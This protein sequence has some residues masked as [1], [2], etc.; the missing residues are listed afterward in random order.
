[1]TVVAEPA[2]AGGPATRRAAAGGVVPVAAGLAVFGLATYG[3]LAFAGRAL[4]EVAFAPLSVMWTLLN[5]VGIGL[6]LPFEQ[7]LGRT[8]AAR[9]AAGEGN[10]PVV[11]HAARAAGLVLA[12]SALVAAAGAAWLAP[13]LF[14]GSF[15]LV[16]LTVV[17]LAAMAL[18]YL[19]RGLLSGTGRFGGYGAQLAVDGVL[20]VGG[21]GALALAGVRSVAAFAVVLAVA[22]LLAVLVTTGRPS[23]LIT[24]GPDHGGRGAAV[25]LGTLVAASVASQLLANAGPVVVELL[26]GPDEAAAAGLFTA[27]LVI[28]RVPL[29][30]FAAVQ[31]V[32]LP[33]LAAL[34]AAGER[35]ALRRRAGVVAA[36]TGVLGGI[37]TVVVWLVGPWLVRL[38]FGPG[39]TIG[40][41][42]LAAIAASGALFMLAQ[43]AAQVLL[44]QHA[45]RAVV[46]GWSVGLAALAAACAIPAAADVTAATALVV[47]AGVALAVLGG[48]AVRSLSDGRL[49]RG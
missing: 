34:A 1:M 19:V 25:A 15:A 10:G 8:T 28:A 36:L 22:P 17:A 49:T 18:A 7:E 12:G 6:F 3:Y 41:G 29:F 44:A 20:K 46:L 39:F 13:E 9:A 35:A 30:A 11:R 45:E 24:P 43:V 48:G 16:V 42:V 32:L 23:R 26:A 33:G 5:A 47:G 38:L 31:A 4:G 37:G 40:R 14:A 27:A 2:P 21:A